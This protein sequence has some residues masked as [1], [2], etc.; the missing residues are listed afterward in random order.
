MSVVTARMAKPSG[1]AGGV[2]PAFDRAL[3]AAV[4]HDNVVS[5]TR[6]PGLVAVGVG[7]MSICDN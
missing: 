7:D 1:G 4:I 2:V 3:P 6:G 5:C